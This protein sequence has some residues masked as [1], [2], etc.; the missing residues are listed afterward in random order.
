MKMFRKIASIV[1][2][3]A[4]VLNGIPANSSVAKAE[5]KTYTNGDYSYTLSEDEEGN[6]V[7]T[8]TRY[9]GLATSITVPESLDGYKVISIGNRAFMNDTNL[10]NLV[11]Q[12]NIISI[13]TE[14]FR[15]I[16]KLSSVKLSS[17]IVTIDSA[18]FAGCTT[19]KQ[20]EIPASLEK[21]ALEYDFTGP[22]S[23]SGLETVSF[24][25][26]TTRVAQ[27]LFKG[28]EKLK[29]IA[30]PNGI[31][32]I[33]VG[34]FFNCTALET[35]KMPDT[36]TAIQ[37]EAFRYDAKLSEVK[38]SSNLKT[39]NS[40]A[41]AGCTSLK[42]IE[43]P[44]SLE[45][46]ALDYDFTGPFSESGL[47]TISFEEG[48]TRVAQRLFR[49]CEK[50]TAVT[51]P[52]SVTTIDEG[53][54]RDA[55]GL[56][57]VK[58]P[59]SL[60]SIGVS[61]FYN[62]T[63]L[64]KI[65]IP[66]TVTAIQNEA[67]RFDTKL[68]EVKL[69]SNL[70]TINSEAFAGCTSLKQIKIPASLEKTALDYDFTGPFSESGLETISFEEGTTRVAQ[71]LFR[72]CEKLTAVTIPDSV[73]TID[74][75]A[76]RD[77]KGL[78]KV[79]LSS[80]LK[81]IGVS[82]FYNC[83][84]LEKIEIPDTV[85]A[86]EN[87]AFRF[88]TKLAEVKLSPNLK[89]IN[90]AA[91][92]SCTS[93]KQ[94]EIPASL[95][96]TALEYDFTGPFSDSG[97]ENVSFAKGIKKI[98]QRL[99]KGCKQI[100]EFVVPDGVTSID[101]EAFNGCSNMT[102]ISLPLSI[103]KIED[104][105]FSNCTSLQTI[106]LPNGIT[107]MGN[108]VFGG[109]DSVVAYCN[110]YTNNA[111][112]CIDQ[113][114]SFAPSDEKF[115]DTENK[116]LDRKKSYF[117]AGMDNVSSS[118]YLPMTIHFDV[119]NK[120]KGELSDQKV[121][122]YIPKYTELVEDSIKVNGTMIHN[123][124]YDE[125]RRQLTIPVNADSGAISYS[126]KIKSKEKVVSY[127]YLSANKNGS[128]T[129]ENIDVVN[130]T[131][132]GITLSAP[133]TVSEGKIK[134]SGIA[135][136]ST[137]IDLYIDGEKQGTVTSLKNGSWSGEITIAD[138]MD[139]YT[140]YI[141]ARCIDE[142]DADIS[143]SKDVGYK[144]NAPELE[145]LTLEYNEHDVIKT[146]D[147]MNT[148][149][150][151]PRI[152][153]VP[154][155]PFT[156]KAGFSNNE[157]IEKVYITSTR[158]NEKKLMEATYDAASG[159]YVA[160]GFF[161]ETN[162]SYVPGTIGVEYREKMK[163]VNA[164]EDFDITPYQE[165]MKKDT[166]K[167]KIDYEVNTDK[168]V[169]ATF[170]F[171]EFAQGLD[172]AII[173][174][175]VKYIDTVGYSSL[176]EIYKVCGMDGTIIKYIVPGVDGKS[177]ILN[178]DFSDPDKINMLLYDAFDVGSKIADEVISFN[179]DMSEFG[180][181]QYM[182]WDMAHNVLGNVTKAVGFA[183]KAYGIYMDY[184]DLIDEIDKSDSIQD[185]YAAKQKALELRQDQLA[186]TAL[187]MIM[188]MLVAGST[189]AAPVMAFSVLLGAISALS[190][191]IYDMRVA[192]IKGQTFKLNFVIDP[193]G[194]VY[195]GTTNDKI[196]GATVTAYWIPYDDSDDFWTNKPS[197]TEY[198]TKWNAQEYEQ[199]NALLTNADGKYAWDVPEGWWRIKC[200]KE[201]Y[202]TT[203]SD[204]MTVPPVQTDVNIAMYKIGV[205]KPSNDGNDQPSQ[206][207]D[208]PSQPTTSTQ[209]TTP[210]QSAAP[211]QPTSPSAGPGSSSTSSSA[212][213]TK[214]KK[215]VIRLAKNVSKRTVK[216]SLKKLASNGYQIQIATN[217]KFTKGRKTYA[218]TKV[219]YSIKKL[220]KGKNYYIRV[221]GYNRN[222]SKKL[223]GKWST[224]KKIKIKK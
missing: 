159:L 16:K 148:N 127:A 54:F 195:D 14:A 104:G 57:E 105:A 181:E 113:N 97:L 3:V 118:G 216:L 187:T 27:R 215:A 36:V 222:G 66:D 208:K 153:Y 109:C 72:G 190:G 61:A 149:G 150:T 223:Y 33:D 184:Y 92:A 53:A 178:M 25:E 32:T 39:I 4:I 1:L 78:K 51:I 68:A 176:E 80:S 217:K 145:S 20:I 116:I 154:D 213:I 28:C 106:K 34:A 11:I 90:S 23:G 138:P 108:N 59:S 155:T 196:E 15:N 211:T 186:F 71:R 214:P 10:S 205:E 160:S 200:E 117:Y 94:I 210:T 166:E 49:G 13:G 164:S 99:F 206:P 88:D 125:G 201:G 194:Y 50:L 189:M 121:V 134:V 161:D 168:E 38:L 69:S 137:D 89:T 82:A 96:K 182:K 156:F 95:E 135:P 140:Y 177:Y 120:W 224:V 173:K 6:N 22:F 62:C 47:E 40:A 207:S 58:L 131:F 5:T 103:E 81:S 44:A 73:T 65:E 55:K 179:M 180:S 128:N 119:K 147:V 56:K 193:S 115:V 86:I 163:S 18:A 17:N 12:D 130:E 221:R 9:T 209:P 188:P 170:D 204:W 203:W 70:K 220:K 52:D 67:F 45:K 100:K 112:R 136:A 129:T 198:G 171:S 212:K 132:K 76:F 114:L 151:K 30:L 183:Y 202:Q 46:T 152:Y 165:I 139:C 172:K 48:T 7:A 93:L 2:T 169:K 175:G 19:L 77:A 162:T 43:I 167:A 192:N 157:N 144:E 26:G 87:E 146:C 142:Y 24:E 133:D 123:Y 107:D 111:I 37:N 63:S 35:I 101:L 126:I 8:I 110:Y 199:E 31:K 174:A 219:S 185:K 75:G 85:T 218:T 143:A 84:S 29:T 197:D 98:P 91:F 74:E 122:T 141:E 158:N 42:Q 41:F 191:T 124:N 60:E 21:T 83:T 79:K 64:E 102:N